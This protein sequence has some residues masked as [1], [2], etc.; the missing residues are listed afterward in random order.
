MQSSRTG[1]KRY[2]WQA[3][4]SA[5]RFKGLS[6]VFV[7]GVSERA[8]G[9]LMPLMV[10]GRDGEARPK[11]LKAREMRRVKMMTHMIL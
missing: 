2:E 5:V 1:G 10:K 9:L 7:D 8:E 6:S 4:K 3:F 11:V